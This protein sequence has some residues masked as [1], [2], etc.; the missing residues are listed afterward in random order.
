MTSFAS[1]KTSPSG[2]WAALFLTLILLLS[3][4][5][6]D[7]YETG[8]GQLS[9][10]RVTFADTYSDSSARIASAMTDE[11]DTLVF[12]K[13][14]EVKWA[15]T[16]DSCFRALLY[17]NYNKVEKVYE[18]VTAHSVYVVTPIN[19]KNAKDKPHDPLTFESAW[20]SQN[21]RYLNL[22]IYVK[23]GQTEDDA[24]QR[25]GI[26]CDTIIAHDDGSRTFHLQVLH[27]QNYVPEYYSVQTYMSIPLTRK[28]VNARQG[29]TLDVTIN[30]YNGIIRRQLPF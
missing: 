22:G 26:A 5:Q 2:I 20:L 1:R 4:C 18:A 9:N 16:A 7:D 28:P 13:P 29:D 25:I 8:D 15:Q 17:Y 23:T 10:L 27:E 3:A 24:R 6:T 19:R 14:L 12:A 11:G 21:R 30:T